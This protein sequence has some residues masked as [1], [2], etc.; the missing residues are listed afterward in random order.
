LRCCPRPELY[1]AIGAWLSGCG[2]TRRAGG[3]SFGL[4]FFRN[5]SRAH[6]I[7]RALSFAQLFF[8]A[9][10]FAES[11][12]SQQNLSSP[13][14]TRFSTLFTQTVKGEMLNT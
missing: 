5:L 6:L 7:L 13:F 11:K 8:M 4:G 1:S 14:L 3:A 10:R 9:T 12:R 2:Q